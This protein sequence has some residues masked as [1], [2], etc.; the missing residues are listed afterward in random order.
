MVGAGLVGIA[1]LAANRTCPARQTSQA[2]ACSAA[3]SFNVIS[4]CAHVEAI[5]AERIDGARPEARLVLAVIA[6]TRSRPGLRQIDRIRQKQC[7]PIG[8]PKSETLMNHQ[9]KRRWMRRFGAPRPSLYRRVRTVHRVDGRCRN[10][11]GRPAKQLIHPAVQRM[12]LR[13]ID[14]RRLERPPQFGAGIADDQDRP[15]GRPVAA[16]RNSVLFT[17]METAAQEKPGA[18]QDSFEPIIQVVKGCHLLNTV[19]DGRGRIGAWMDGR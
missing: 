12:P 2:A 10:R 1:P 6:R 18:A 8:V 4:A 19:L 7:T 14:L 15:S 16:C 11:I 5:R 13:R 9:P 3:L 17:R